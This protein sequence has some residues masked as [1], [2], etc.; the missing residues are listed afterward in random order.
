MSTVPT[1]PTPGDDRRDQSPDPARPLEHARVYPVPR[2]DDDPR[3]TF[4]LTLDVADALGRH[5][6]PIAAGP[7]FV[8]LQAALFAFLY[9]TADA[10]RN[11]CGLCGRG[12]P[13]GDELRTH[14]RTQHGVWRADS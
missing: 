7:D 2:P 6:F 11:A 8:A 10:N 3:F 14:L 9:D 1:P 4:G 5:G 12:F 13:D